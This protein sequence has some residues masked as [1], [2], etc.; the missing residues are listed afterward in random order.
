MM[1]ITI[2]SYGSLVDVLGDTLTHKATN[3]DALIDDINKAFPKLKNSNFV[4][5]VNNTV[6]KT[7]TQLKQGDQVALMPPYSGG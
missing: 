6:I 7:N 1:S 3:T 4:I 2:K 5:A